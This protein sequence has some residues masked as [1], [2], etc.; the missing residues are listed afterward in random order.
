VAFSVGDAESAPGTLTVGAT[1]SNPA[2]LPNANIVLAPTGG[3]GWQVTLTPAPNRHGSAVVTLTVSD[4]GASTTTTF[5]VN[6]S[7]V[8]DAPA[9][10]TRATRPRG[11]RPSRSRLPGC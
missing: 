11:T 6:V 9:R 8:N 5:V 1:S 4:G 10:P 2:L 3:G 7:A